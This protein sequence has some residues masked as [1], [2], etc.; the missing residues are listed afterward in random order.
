MTLLRDLW[1]AFPALTRHPTFAATA[2]YRGTR[3]RC[4]ATQDRTLR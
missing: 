2:S 3:R 4:C 1:Y